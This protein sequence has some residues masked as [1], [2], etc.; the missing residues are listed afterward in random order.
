MEFTFTAIPHPPPT[1]KPPEPPDGQHA[2]SDKDTIMKDLSV[3]WKDALVVKLLGKHLRYNIMKNKLKNVWKLMGGI[4]LMDVRSS[5]YMVKFDGEEDK[6]KVINGGPWMIY[7]HYFVMRQWTPSFNASTTKIDKTMVWIRIPSL[8]LAFYDESVLWAL[9]SMVGNPIKV[10]L[11]T[12]KV[13]R[14][15]F[16]R[17]CVEV[18]LTKPVVGRVGINGEWY[19]VHCTCN[20]DI[21]EHQVQPP[22]ADFIHNSWPVRALAYLHHKE[23]FQSHPE[24]GERSQT[25][26]GKRK[27]SLGVTPACIQLFKG[28]PKAA[29]RLYLFVKQHTATLQLNNSYPYAPLS[30]VRRRNFG[31]QSQT[32]QFSSKYMSCH[33]AELLAVIFKL[34]TDILLGQDSLIITHLYTEVKEKDM[35]PWLLTVVYTSPRENE[36]S[37][38]RHHIS[39]LATTITAPWLV[40][41][42]LMSAILWR[43]LLREQSLLGGDLNGIE[44]TEYLKNLIEFFVMSL[45]GEPNEWRNRPFRFEVAWNTHENFR[46]VIH[47]N[48]TRGRDLVFLL[49]NLT[50]ISKCGTKSNFL[51]S[52]EKELQDQLAYTLY[53]EECLW[54]QKSRGKWIADGDRNT[55]YYHSK[56][57]IRRR[58]NKIVSLRN[59]AGHCIEDQENLSNMVR[60]FYLSLYH[61]DKPICDPIISWTTYPQNLDNEQ[62]K[63]S[64]PVLY[65]E[66][67]KALF[68]MGSHKSPGEDG[69]PALLF[70]QNWDIV[71]DSVYHFVNQVEA[72]YWKPM[73]A[74]Q[75]INN[76][77][78]QIFFSKNVDEQVKNDIV[79]HTG[80]TPV[81]GF[82][83]YLGANIASGRTTRGKFNHI[84]G[85]IQN[86]LSGWKHQCLSLAGR[87]TLTKSDLSFIP[88]YHMHK[89][90]RNNDLKVS[91]NNQ[92]YDSPLW[93][94]LVGIGDQLQCHTLWKVGNGQ[95]INSW[96]D[97]WMPNGHTVMILSTQQIIDTTLTLAKDID[98][99]DLLGWSGT[100]TSQFTVQNAYDLQRG[101]NLSIEGNWESL[102]R[103]NGPHRIQTFMWIATHERLLTNYRRSRWGNGTSPT[104]PA[105]GQE[106]ET[107]L[108]VLRDCMFATQIWIRLVA[109]NHITDS[110]SLTCRDWIVDNISGAHTKDWHTIFMVTC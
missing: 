78:T 109:S 9:A 48:W 41:G 91:M 16:A 24:F 26:A 70:Q 46:Q 52:L 75:K 33:Y 90:G 13:A 14:G 83:K 47:E 23:E 72:S 61:E 44:G 73:C 29:Q 74:G 8:N 35:D 69:Y 40:M 59:E 21:L 1:Q 102:W 54:Y 12:L 67:K 27:H 15:R 107:I 64:S 51:E 81:N 85:K 28:Y 6:N 88:Y 42:G 94:A 43:L 22:A 32:D 25:N 58:R 63:L 77:K 31:D 86:R 82:D 60:N 19:H 100:S 7:D 37:E 80:Y 105:C 49:S 96:L 2:K 17:M 95:K 5:F 84:I 106:D 110:L 55:K 39:Q 89:Y 99:P 57:I 62:H 71:A 92:P 79:Q 103:W 53:Q 108:H 3:P 98:G 97:K 11:Q 104:C 18:D 45:G 4:E 34:P 38:T 65:S 66:C 30:K 50:D 56:T 10:D 68:D 20:K 36:R 76:Q 87:L 101:N 93:K